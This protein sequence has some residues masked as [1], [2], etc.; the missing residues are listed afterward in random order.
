MR[1]LLSKIYARLRGILKVRVREP[2]SVK[3]GCLAAWRFA[4]RL[5]RER[6][7]QSIDTVQASLL[8]LDLGVC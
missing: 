8:P 7:C 5:M 3:G 2:H 4:Q 1:Q 6:Q